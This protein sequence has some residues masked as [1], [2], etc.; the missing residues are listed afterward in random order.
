MQ[1]YTRCFVHGDF[2][3]GNI[4]FVGEKI[5]GLIDTDWCRASVHFE[6]IAYLIVMMLRDYRYD[7][8]ESV[9]VNLLE[10]AMSWYRISGRERFDLIEYIVATAAHEMHLFSRYFP[11]SPK[12]LEFQRQMVE[13]IT[14]VL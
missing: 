7:T 8:F 6:D 9:D 13:K 2:H 11:D 12:H 3:P 14:D 1:I 10:Q 4:L 5:N